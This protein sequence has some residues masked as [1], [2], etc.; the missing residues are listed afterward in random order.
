MELDEAPLTVGK[1]LGAAQ[2]F[3][4]LFGAYCFAHHDTCAA[5]LPG[6]VIRALRRRL[7]RS[8]GLRPLWVFLRPALQDVGS[9]NSRCSEKMRVAGDALVALAIGQ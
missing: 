2:H 8:P 3:L 7:A 1:L 4:A 9:L 6:V 5:A